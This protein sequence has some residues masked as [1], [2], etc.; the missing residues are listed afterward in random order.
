MIN[1]KDI[2]DFFK[3][4]SLFSNSETNEKVVEFPNEYK[5]FKKKVEELVKDK[6]ISIDLLNFIKKDGEFNFNIFFTNW[7]ALYLAKS[8][9][10]K[11]DSSEKLSKKI[12]NNLYTLVCNKKMLNSSLMGKAFPEYN[13][14]IS[15]LEKLTDEDCNS[16]K[17]FELCYL[18]YFLNQ[19]SDEAFL[20]D[21]KILFKY[22]GKVDLE[23]VRNFYILDY[24]VNIINLFMGT[25][26]LTQ[27]KISTNFLNLSSS[28]VKLNNETFPCVLNLEIIYNYMINILKYVKGGSEISYNFLFQPLE[29]NKKINELKKVLKIY[30]N[31]YEKAY[32]K[33]LNLYPC[34]F[35][36]GKL[37]LNEKELEALIVH[38][39]LKKLKDT[40]NDV[41][42][43]SFKKYIDEILLE[44]SK[45]LNSFFKK[46]KILKTDNSILLTAWALMKKMDE[47]LKVSNVIAKSVKRGIKSFSKTKNP[48]ALASHIDVSN[49]QNNNKKAILKKLSYKYRLNLNEINKNNDFNNLYRIVKRKELSNNKSNYL[50]LM[51]GSLD[52]QLIYKVDQQ[53]FILKVIKEIG[54]KDSLS[55]FKKISVDKDLFSAFEL[56]YLCKMD[57]KVNQ[58]IKQRKL[59]KF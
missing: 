23:S 6:K 49:K 47:A 41:D 22:K 30:D 17:F 15:N 59:R 52:E 55:I 37:S 10:E 7:L 27:K 56:N 8:W 12:L 43:V 11:K 16:L 2:N 58:P 4:I 13:Q 50:Y 38:A 21:F 5:V 3:D 53:D 44:K 35:R 18:S 36:F 26:K 9:L 51:F 14:V 25:E 29:N 40:L 24:D 20:L 31:L 33:G 54:L 1:Q 57:L 39:T 32:F 34:N 28:I 42:C 45:V 48:V 19:E 46:Y